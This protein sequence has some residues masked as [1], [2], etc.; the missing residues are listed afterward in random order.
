MAVDKVSDNEVLEIT[1]ETDAHKGSAFA[2]TSLHGKRLADNVV[3]NY[4]FGS[5]GRPAPPTEGPLVAKLVAD[6]ATVAPAEKVRLDASSSSGGKSPLEFQ[7]SF[8]EYT[9]VPSKTTWQKEPITDFG[10][11]NAGPKS[12]LVRVRDATGK[13]V[14]SAPITITVG[15]TTPPTPEPPVTPPP[16][17]P[18]PSGAIVMKTRPPRGRP[19]FR[20]VGEN[21][22][23]S[24][25]KRMEVRVVPQRTAK[26]R[27]AVEWKWAGFGSCS[28]YG[29]GCYAWGS[30]DQARIDDCYLRCDPATGDPVESSVFGKASRSFAEGKAAWKKLNPGGSEVIGF[31]PS[32]AA[33]D[34]QAG[35]PI[36]YRYDP[37]SNVESHGASWDMVRASAEAG[38]PHRANTWPGDYLGRQSLLA[39]EVARVDNVY[40][41]EHRGGQAETAMP[42]LIIVYEDGVIEPVQPLYAYHGSGRTRAWRVPSDK[43]RLVAVGANSKGGGGSITWSCAGKSGSVLHD[44]GYDERDVDGKGTRD[45]KGLYPGV[46]GQVFAAGA[47]VALSA[48][49]D[50]IL[51]MDDGSLSGFVPGEEIVTGAGLWAVFAA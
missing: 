31:I 20:G 6:K 34:L 27:I 32:G 14:A 19:G 7:F 12:V 45:E 18:P 4:D 36:W 37:A 41:G 13:I 30:I 44:G 16:V 26:G 1:K 21:V 48:S 49:F 17:E 28:R 40:G 9:F 47:S 10:F 38:G 42:T 22:E 35:V 25:K 43:P 15:A 5:L 24:Q 23:D 46:S 8:D 51:E 2:V 39:C 29:S 3:T 11:Q 33:V 50:C